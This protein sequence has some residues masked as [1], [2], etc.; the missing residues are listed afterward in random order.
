[1]NIR[2]IKK[3]K[4][5][6]QVLLISELFFKIIEVVFLLFHRR[7]PIKLTHLIITS[8]TSNPN[9]TENSVIYKTIFE[10]LKFQKHQK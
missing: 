5:A 1:M 10:R 4:Q 3:I 2:F 8:Q 9:N 6:S 7:I